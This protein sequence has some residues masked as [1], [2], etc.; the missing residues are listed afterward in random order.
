MTESISQPAPERQAPRIEG[1]PA[2]LQVDTL[3]DIVNYQREIARKFDEQNE[4]TDFAAFKERE[5]DALL[6]ENGI[7]ESEDDEQQH[8]DYEFA[9]AIYRDAIHMNEDEWLTKPAGSDV[10]RRNVKLRAIRERY[11]DRAESGS[12]GSDEANQPVDPDDAFEQSRTEE[13][14]RQEARSHSE[15]LSE[16]DARMEAVI[17]KYAEMVAERSKRM[18]E[19]AKTRENIDALKDGREV[20]LED[21]KVVY[22]PG[23]ADLIGAVATE[24]YD[25]LEADGVSQEEIV[26]QIDEFVATQTDQ[27]V[28]QMEAH[29]MEEYNKARPI[30]KKFYDKWAQWGEQ[31]MKGNV[32]KAAVFA[33]PGAALGVALVPLAGVVGFGA[34]GGALAVTGARSVGRRLAGAHIDK[35]ADSKKVAEAQSEDIRNKIQNTENAAHTDI[36]AII[37]ERSEAYRKRNLRRTAG[38]LA[39]A[40]TAGLL[41]AKAADIIADNVDNW[42]FGKL[43]PNGDVEDVDGK[44]PDIRDMD[45]DDIPDAIDADRDG[46][47]VPNTNDPAPNN[48]DVDGRGGPD[49]SG[50]NGSGQDGELTRNELFDGRFGTRDLTLEGHEALAEQLDGYRVQPGDSVWSLSEQF[51][52]DQGIQNPTVYEIDATKDVLLAELKA[53][54]SVD[55]RGWLSAGD[56]IHIK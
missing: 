35:R 27:V 48:P 54:E 6:A 18:V 29:R 51:L 40:L 25:D 26:R 30:M 13:E 7:F 32:K 10:D 50:P 53:T 5:I 49:G 31:G 28:A 41:S 12:E 47:N 8:A 23:L 56:T 46:D 16:T 36:L 20:T 55:S 17:S 37:D 14:G 39:I 44:G 45:N 42:S 1:A 9:K 11:S 15:A 38:G 2:G 21:G 43:G 24:M 34:A 3:D 19:G 33:V 22:E 4:E 52:K